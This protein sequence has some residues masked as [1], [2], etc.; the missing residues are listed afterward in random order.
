MMLT[1]VLIIVLLVLANAVFSGAEIAVVAL[2]KNRIQ[3]LAE[4]GRGSARAVL[5]LREHPEMFLATV[6]VGITVVGAT[7][8]AFGGSSLAERLEPYLARTPWLA[9]HAEG[10]ALAIV[11]SAVS[12][13]SIVVG[14]LVPKSLALRGAERYALLVARP[15]L[16]L[17]TAARP[18]VWVLSAS[19]N[20]LLKPFGDKTTFTE[21]RY[22]PD[23]LQ[24]LVEEAAEAGTVHPEAA[25][26]ATRA[27][28]LPELTAEE[29]MVPRRDVVA[30]AQN[31][32]PDEIRQ[33]LLEQTHSRLPVY[34]GVID[35]VVGYIAVKDVLALAW[36]ARLV[37]LRDMIRPPFFVPE[38]KKAVDLLKEMRVRRLPFA[39]VVDE[40]GGMS[41]IITMED[42]L[43]ELVGE[44]FHEHEA[45]NLESI[46]PSSDDS[47][48]VDGSASI[49]D[50]NRA[51]N[52]ELPDDG[53]W[54]TLAGYVLSLSGRM[55]KTGEKFTVD[56]GVTLEVVEASQR[57]VRTLRVSGLAQPGHG[58]S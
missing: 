49:R 6:Q 24:Q 1:E 56:G 5:A 58:G 44:I 30:I 9:R 38:P 13:L 27:L 43:E 33:I 34:D 25:Q 29:V 45:G 39:I 2:R 46:R 14:E 42:L 19:A 57:R 50:V 18:L 4:Q 10:V 22:S 51:L 23:D 17:S 41:G 55:P 53:A 15:L 8:A 35:N 47:V 31:A 12:Y 16:W 21:T 36:D 20:V 52:L 37:I 7:A 11:I 32:T 28:A 48:L 54:T 40:H 26:I 3:E